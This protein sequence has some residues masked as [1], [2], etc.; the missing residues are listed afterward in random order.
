[1]LVVS[2]GE[3]MVG[4]VLSFVSGTFLIGTGTLDFRK[5]VLLGVGVVFF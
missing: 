4:G 5:V 3:G 1:M 2:F